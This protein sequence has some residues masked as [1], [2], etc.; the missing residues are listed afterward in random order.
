MRLVTERDPQ[1]LTAQIQVIFRSGS[2]SDPEPMPGL[3]HFTGRVLLR[4]TRKRSA[5]ELTAAIERLGASLT[6]RTDQ[7]LT[8]LRGAVLARNWQP[9]LDL[10]REVLTEPAFDPGEVETLKNTLQGELRASLQDAQE[11]ATHALFRS[12]YAGTPAARVPEGTLQ[13]LARV[14][15]AEL[16]DFFCRHYVHHNMIVGVSSPLD[17]LQ[18]AQDVAQTLELMPLGIENLD[19]L[20]DATFGGRGS[21]IVDREGLST[22]PVYVIA[23]GVSDADADLPV[24]ELGNFAFGGDF[25]SR[26]MQVIRAENGWTYGISSDYWQVTAPKGRPGLF[27]IY[28]FPSSEYAA[29]ALPKTL[30]M[31]EEYARKGL[32]EEEF[33]KARD[34]LRNSYAFRVATADQRLALKLREILTGRPFLTPQE[35]EEW[36][37]SL[38]LRQ[39][40]ETIERRLPLEDLLV[41]TVGAV[42]G[43]QP[44]LASLPGMGKIQTW[45]PESIAQ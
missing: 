6:V 4:G 5:H 43:L 42:S 3:A 15:P 7:D 18:V 36:I 37:S 41:M 44:I 19:A 23:P 30:E 10:L 24:L 13:G 34:A 45:A 35:H 39:V 16:R 11:L 25:T 26:L 38:T 31:L 32:S 29:L 28:L 40:N 33:E 20:P 9:F 21:V 27:T 1:A 17:E 22:S 14:T 8:V 12:A 2:L